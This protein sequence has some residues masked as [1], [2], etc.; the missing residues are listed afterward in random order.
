MARS[1]INPA[2]NGEGW[3]VFWYDPDGKQRQQTLNLKQ[4]ADAVRA[5][6]QRELDLGVFG[7][8]R[9]SKES[10]A[11]VFE[12]W[13][14]TR[15]VENS[16]VK[17]Y[18]TILNRSIIPFFGSRSIAAIK[19]S[20]VQEWIA[21]MTAT[22]SY[23][24]STL[25]FRLNILRSV[26]TWAVEG[27]LIGRN[28]CKEAKLP[29]SRAKARRVQKAEVI[30]PK[31][32]DVLAIINESSARYRGMLWLMV[33]CGFRLGEAMGISRDRI[34]FKAKMITVDRQ[35]AGDRDTG[36][37][38][39][40]GQQLRHIKWRD[41]DDHGRQVPLPDTVALALRRHL[42]QYG[43][44]GPDFLLFSNITRTGFLYPEYWYQK[45]WMPALAGAKVAYFR[46]HGL[47]HFY[48][49]ALLAQGVPMTEVSAWLGHSSVSVTE[50]YYAHLMPDAPDRGR[51]AI[52]AALAPALPAVE[53]EESP[54]EEVA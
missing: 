27:E 10:L 45:I 49:S 53:D 47:R 21:W 23:K 13:A 16:S 30:V 46:S 38:K 24:E 15:G 4:D 34:D 41:E 20:D 40:G 5:K 54:V 2:K 12:R 44:W 43:T 32:E 39:Y 42:K 50:Q 22:Y 52:D 25:Q 31:L 26:F 17:Q 11:S 48:A 7:G 18:R 28:P 1:W 3:T 9:L 29:G 35:V 14:T 19:L 8:V 37:G 51:Q 6:I 33:G 36:T